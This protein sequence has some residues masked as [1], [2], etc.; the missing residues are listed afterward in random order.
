LV[1]NK[2]N[3]HLSASVGGAITILADAEAEYDE[4]LLKAEALLG[5]F[6]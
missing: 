5:L 4:C 6:T 3:K 2:R 1:Y